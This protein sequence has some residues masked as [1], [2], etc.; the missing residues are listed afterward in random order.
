[1]KR[2]IRNLWT[3]ALRDGKYEQTR[4]RLARGTHRDP[5]FCCLGVL[6]DLHASAAGQLWEGDF[7]LDEE[8]SLPQEVLEWAGLPP[9]DPSVEIEGE[10][11]QTTLSQ[12]NDDGDDFGTIAD[13]IESHL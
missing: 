2:T 9:G 4:G 10:A 7:Y 5:S 8:I 1:M 6:C 3:A 11:G 12:I 13:I